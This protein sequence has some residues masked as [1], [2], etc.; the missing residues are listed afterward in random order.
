MSRGLS[1]SWLGHMIWWFIFEKISNSIF[2]LPSF[3]HTVGLVCMAV[4]AALCIAVHAHM[5]W[6]VPQ[7][8]LITLF[9]LMLLLWTWMYSTLVWY[10]ISTVIW[11]AVCDNLFRLVVWWLNWALTAM[12]CPYRAISCNSPTWQFHQRFISCHSFSFCCW[13]LALATMPCLIQS[14]V[15]L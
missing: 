3:A 11:P 8:V 6:L 13:W 15:L 2:L 12:S 1:F 9:W 10:V 14:G 4:E 5:V 7:L